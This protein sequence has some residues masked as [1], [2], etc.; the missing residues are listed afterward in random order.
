MDRL[1]RQRGMR[2]S[3]GG[4][5]PPA[6][7]HGQLGAQVRTLLGELDCLLEGKRASFLRGAVERSVIARGCARHGH[8]RVEPGILRRRRANRWTRAW[9]RLGGEPEIRASEQRTVDEE[10]HGFELR[11]R[12]PRV[13]L[14]WI[15]KRERGRSVRFLTADAERLAAAATIR[16]PAHRRNSISAV[17]A[18]TSSRCSQLS[19]RIG[20]RSSFSHSMSVCVIVGAM[21]CRAILRSTAAAGS[22]SP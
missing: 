20:S 7:V 3:A 1:A 15:G 22:T 8:A 16:M 18:Q 17:F 14:L 12:F 2:F 10:L 9:K 19:S 21:Q 4:E 13:R 5:R 11:D 6:G